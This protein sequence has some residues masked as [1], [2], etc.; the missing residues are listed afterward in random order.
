LSTFRY[1]QSF[2]IS[3][4]TEAIGL[5]FHGFD[6]IFCSEWQNEGIHKSKVGP[7]KRSSENAK[8]RRLIQKM[9]RVD[10]NYRWGLLEKELLLPRLTRRLK[11]V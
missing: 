7:N 5:A 4:I 10:D 9:R 2:A 6:F 1:K 3:L 8:K 11:K